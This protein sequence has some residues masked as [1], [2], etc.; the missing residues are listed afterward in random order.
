MA[1]GIA[2][3]VVPDRWAARCAA[4]SDRIPTDTLPSVQFQ[5]PDQFKLGTPAWSKQWWTESLAAAAKN[6]S[7]LGTFRGALRIEGDELDGAAGS[8]GGRDMAGVRDTWRGNVLLTM[9]PDVHPDGVAVRVN[10]S[11][12]AKAWAIPD[13]SS[14]VDFPAGG[15]QMILA[16]TPAGR[17]RLVSINRDSGKTTWCQELGDLGDLN[18]FGPAIASV[19]RSGSLFL[20]E[21]TLA[22]S[23]DSTV[24]ISR[25]NLADG[26]LLW[27]VPAA[28]FHRV[29]T[30]EPFQDLVLVARTGPSL[31]SNDRYRQFGD[32]PQP[33]GNVV[34]ARSAADGGMR[35]TYGG[36][37]KSGWMN[38]IVGIDGETAVVLSQRDQKVWQGNVR[39]ERLHPEDALQTTSQLIGLGA[40]GKER[41]RQDLGNRLYSCRGFGT[42]I[43]AGVA[44]SVEGD[45]HQ[46]FENQV[47]VARDSRTGA[48]RW[49]TPVADYTLA[50]DFWG[51]RLI[52]DR[53][54]TGSQ[55]EKL[56]SIDLRTGAI[57]HPL[58]ENTRYGG[59]AIDDQSVTI[60][61][62]GL[63]LTFDRPR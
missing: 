58:G 25:R 57:D 2:V 21:P 44:L 3:R 34:Q 59:I 36:P 50:P 27:R 8:F 46:P 11:A 53:L 38:S 61:A 54:L 56:I 43:E 45:F 18:R 31:S 55:G 41:W 49:R 5:A 6:P 33:A 9:Y 62:S 35:W 39:D 16:D 1:G 48:I 17:A 40:D 37:D 22:R 42:A 26:K 51:Y 24:M 10:R 52:G 14:S 60:D 32:S 28:G 47:L 13:R 30:V 4:V 20:A 23:E 7:A 29:A 15:D 19:P 63:L 12:D